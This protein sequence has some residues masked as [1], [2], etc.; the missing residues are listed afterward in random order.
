MRKGLDEESFLQRYT[1]RGPKSVWSQINVANVER[2]TKE[3]KMKPPGQAHVD[4]AKADGRWASAY[5]QKTHEPPADLVAAIRADARASATYDTLSAQNRF[6][7]TFRTMSLKTVE[8][9]AKKV[10]AFVE[11]LRKGETIHPQARPKKK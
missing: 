5:R 3:G 7:L 2:L 4:A 1:R 9:R 6:A 11:M 8:G 10:A